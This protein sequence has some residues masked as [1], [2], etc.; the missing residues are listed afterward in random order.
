ME[1]RAI[2]NVR[3]SCVYYVTWYNIPED[4]NAQQRRSQSSKPRI[5]LTSLVNEIFILYILDQ[6]SELCHNFE[7]FHNCLWFVVLFR[8]VT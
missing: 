1:I 5:P 8:I 2:R 3:N 4:L 7:A 6:I